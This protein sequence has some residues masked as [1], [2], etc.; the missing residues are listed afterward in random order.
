MRPSHITEGATM[1]R[2]LEKTVHVRWMIRAD[3]EA[4]YEIENHSF[5]DP[6]K[7]DDFVRVIKQT[8]NIAMVAVYGERIVGFVIY[9]I[10]KSNRVEILNMAVHEDWRYK[11]IGAALVNKIRRK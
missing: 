9:E 4:V 6:W 8:R 10:K 5:S 11:G 1:S 3:R 2:A 7:P